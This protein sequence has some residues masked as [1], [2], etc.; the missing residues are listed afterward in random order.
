M[1]TQKNSLPKNNFPK[2][3]PITNEQK[4]VMEDMSPDLLAWGQ[5]G[6]GKTQVGA[7]KALLIATLYPGN[8]IYLIRRKKVD[9]RITLWKRFADKITDEM[10]VKK[11]EGRMYFRMAN[12]RFQSLF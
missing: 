7:D 9:L 5:G 4:E 6:S 1:W 11:D 12:G 10:I 3:S 8:V 2:I